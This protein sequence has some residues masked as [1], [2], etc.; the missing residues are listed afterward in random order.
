MFILLVDNNR[1]HAS[2]LKEMLL[3]AGFD[4]VGYAEN[5]IECAIQVYDESPDVVI[6]DESQ[7]FING[8]DIIKNIHIT[9]P[10]TRII[11]LTEDEFVLHPRFGE[12]KNPV[13][14]FLKSNITC[15]N[16]PQLLYSIFTER[17]KA[18]RPS[19][20]T[21]FLSFRKSFASIVNS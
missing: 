14:Y 1:F 2:V 21:A 18:Y 11:V 16:L 5:G 13:H 17:L 19:V 4:T 10:E 20:N 12:D 9:R 8:V 3:K 6:I 15:E 7:C